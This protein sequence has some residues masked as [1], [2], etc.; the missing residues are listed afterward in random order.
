MKYA[1]HR[2][3]TVTILASLM[4]TSGLVAANWPQWRGLEQ[5]ATAD[6]ADW[7][8]SKLKEKPVIKWRAAVG[9]GYSAISA[10]DGM[11]FTMGN[12]E[13]ND[14]VIALETRTGKEL[15][16]HTYPCNAGKFRGPRS[17]PAYIG[18]SL[19][20]LSREGLLIKFN[21]DDGRIIW[22]KHLSDFGAQAPK[23]GY[24]ASPIVYDNKLYINVCRSGIC[25]DLRSGDPLWISPSEPT[26]Y[27]STV[28]FEV[29][30][31][32][33][34]LAFG[35]DQIHVSD[36]A[37]GQVLHSLPWKTSYNV[38]AADPLM[39]RG[40]FIISSGYGKG[41]AFIQLTRRGL[42]TQWE[43][44]ALAAHTDTPLYINGIVVGVTGKAQQGPL[45]AIDPTTGKE[46]WRFDSKG[47]TVIGAGDDIIF[48][49]ANRKIHVATASRNGFSPRI[50]HLLPLDGEIWT[51][52]T[53]SDGRL[54]CRTTKG[55]LIC[56]DVAP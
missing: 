19:F 34:L 6:P 32:S 55:D 15:W 28:P 18:G 47:G 35:A 40:G 56:I 38:N 13:G 1:A 4:A 50:T 21:A 12:T 23:W 29:D 48:L 8:P 7:N 26:G 14:H 52:A 11:L 42:E 49:E 16:R 31:G 27:A 44:K 36:A 53:L 17:T 22:T 46:L 41:S 9:D 5:S 51:K 10:A 39:V 3:I 30:K 45:I 20:T 2:L 37:T 24:A 25:L 54:Y 33:R 43:N